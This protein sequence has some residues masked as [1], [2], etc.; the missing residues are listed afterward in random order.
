MPVYTARESAMV[1]ILSQRAL[2]VLVSMEHPELLGALADG[3]RR[4]AEVSAYYD[5]MFNHM[6]RYPQ[7]LL[8]ALP[9]K[10]HEDMLALFKDVSGDVTRAVWENRMK[11]T[12]ANPERR[13]RWPHRLALTVVSTKLRALGR[14]AGGQATYKQLI[15]EFRDVHS[16]T[17]ELREAIYQRSALLVEAVL[18]AET[19]YG[20]GLADLEE[21]TDDRWRW[22]QALVHVFDDLEG[23]PIPP[24]SVA[25]LL[26]AGCTSAVDALAAAAADASET[27]PRSPG[28]NR[29]SRLHLL[30]SPLPRLRP[31]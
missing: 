9:R 28:A 16:A 13:R 12:A 22:L 6:E 15:E 5:E 31:I 4:R 3:A 17:D 29:R 1:A 7:A 20:L 11:N 21:S 23:E 19:I 14:V 18:E 8:K 26:L 10:S 24:D 30:D 2:Q 27:P 25:A